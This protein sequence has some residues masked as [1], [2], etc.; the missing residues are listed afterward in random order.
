MNADTLTLQSAL[1]GDRRF[2]VP[3][4]QR[5]YVWEQERQWEPLWTD[6][7]ATALRL[8]EGGEGSSVRIFEITACAVFPGN[9]G[10][11]HNISKSTQPSE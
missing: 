7:E 4:Y 5:P 11:P 3:V 6:V 10:S 8:A 9:G 2:V 1:Q